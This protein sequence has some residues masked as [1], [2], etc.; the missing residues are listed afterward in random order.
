MKERH[1]S[2]PPKNKGKYV[3]IVFDERS[4]LLPLQ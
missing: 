2:T 1:K 3:I 4:I